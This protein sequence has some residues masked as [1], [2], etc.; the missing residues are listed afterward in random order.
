MLKLKLS[1]RQPSTGWS[2]IWSDRPFIIT[3]SYGSLK[4]ETKLEG[5][6]LIASGFVNKVDIDGRAMPLWLLWVGTSGEGGII[7][8]TVP[9]FTDMPP[10]PQFVALEPGIWAMTF[11]EETAEPPV[12]EPPVEPPMEESPVEEPPSEETPPL[13][14]KNINCIIAARP[15]TEIPPIPKAYILYLDASVLEELAEKYR[16]ALVEAL[17]KQIVREELNKRNG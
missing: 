12:E 9:K 11:E 13:D 7:L 4:S 10:S 15:G 8:S 17:G 16:E 14:P 6:K 3:V 5:E 2:Q 1:K